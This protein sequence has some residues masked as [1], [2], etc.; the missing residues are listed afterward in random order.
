MI[1]LTDDVIDTSEVL[2]QAGSL[3]AGAV[4]LFM[5]TTREFTGERRTAS[6]DYECYPEMAEVKLTELEAANNGWPIGLPYL[7]GLDSAVNLTT[8][9]LEGNEISDVGPLASL[10]N[11][12]KVYL[13]GNPLNDDAINRQIP[14]LKAKGI[15]VEL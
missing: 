13:R 4:V 14:A 8:L 12:N 1:A 9:N 6:L 7:R 2:R 15:D 3:R 11:L 5:G 10:T